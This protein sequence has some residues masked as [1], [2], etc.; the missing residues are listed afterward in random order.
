MNQVIGAEYGAKDSSQLGYN[1]PIQLLK[2]SNKS[3]LDF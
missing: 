3:W 1:F 2:L